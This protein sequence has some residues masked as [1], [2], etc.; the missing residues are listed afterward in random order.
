[1]K[2]SDRAWKKRAREEG[3]RDFVRT[4]ADEL[5][6]RSGFYVDL[7][8]AERVFRFFERV[9][10]HSKGRWGGQPF[11]LESWQKS[12]LLGPIFGWM[13]PDGTRRFR[14]AHIELPKKNGKSTIA[15]GVGLYML[16]GDGEAGADVFSAATRREQ[17]SLV[18]DEAINMTKASPLLKKALHI[19]NTTKV[20]A[21]PDTYSRYRVL[22]SDA[23]GAEG[24]NIHC[25]ICDELHAWK[26]RK[27]WDSLRYGFAARKQPLAFVITTAGL[28]DVTSLGWTEHEYADRVVRGD[29][30]D[31]EFF[32]YIRAA[33]KTAADGDGYLDPE[34]HRRANPNYGITIQAD[35]IAK[36]ARDAKEKASERGPFLRYRLNLWVNEASSFFDMERWRAC[37]GVVDEDQLAGRR[38]FGGLDLANKNDIAAWVLAFPPTESDSKWRILPRFFVPADNAEKREANSGAKYATWGRAGLI[39]LTDGNRIDYETIRRQITTDFKAFD[40]AEVGA[41][42]WNLEY[43]RQLLA[44]ELDSNELILAVR[45]NFRELSAPTKELESLI[46][47][48]SLA[49]GGNEVLTWMAGNCVPSEDD[50]ENVKISRRRSKEKIDGIAALV[51]ALSRA[52]V[53][54][55]DEGSVW[56]DPDYEPIMI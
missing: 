56:D 35:E 25:L 46:L 14:R 29:V 47:S 10:R 16:R 13:R 36:A 55:D 34:Q 52:M 42:E 51:M 39:T 4:D 30:V 28:Y 49:H 40:V 37:S 15:A 31:F 27:F 50:M 7:V 1:M 19:N 26:G 44:D 5:A 2:V 33:D 20:I 3:W 53:Q 23:E 41:D 11:L 45:Q 38:C 22:A 54:S 9:L 12:D 18:H 21:W 17:A 24:L 48:E 8:A 43:L 32:S 6:C